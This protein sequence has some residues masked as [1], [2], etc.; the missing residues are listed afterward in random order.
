MSQFNLPHGRE[1]NGG[2]GRGQ[3][4]KHFGLEPPLPATTSPLFLSR[5][6]GNVILCASGFAAGDLYRPTEART[7]PHTEGFDVDGGI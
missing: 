3:A 4:P 5:L 2:K 1:G 6:V 7:R